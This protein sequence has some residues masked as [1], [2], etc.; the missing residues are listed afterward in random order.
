VKTEGNKAVL[1]TGDN[2]LELENGGRI[3]PVEAAYETYGRLNDEKTNAIL[4]LHAFSG[5]AYA[6]GHKKGEEKPG[7]WDSMIGAKKAFDTDKYFIIC[8]NVVGGCSGTTGPS[9]INPATG[10]PYGLEFPAVTINDM[11]DVQKRLVDNLGIK[12]LLSIAGGSMGGMQALAWMVK[13]PE[14]INSSIVIAASH[15]HSPQ[16]IAFH[17]VGRQAIMADP[18]WMGGDYYGKSVPAK[19]LALARM[20]GHITYMSEQSME[21]KFGRQRKSGAS[22]FKFNADFEVEHYLRYRGDSFVKRFDANS[23]LY[24]SKAMDKFDASKARPLE[25]ALKGHEYKTMVISFTSDWLYPS[26]HSKEIVKACKKSGVDATYC[27]I[28]SK[29][30]HDAFL[31]ETEQQSHLIGHFLEKVR[32][33]I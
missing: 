18:D 24:L 11:V 8:S 14:M 5:S 26:S 23:Y 31:L 3:G 15:K 32:K 13:Y 2:P 10:K 22:E 28:D 20:L 17:E 12:K 1:W 21:E 19:G 29:Y 9:S 7:W 4:V 6:S 33:G 30:G 25:S 27:E 16:Q